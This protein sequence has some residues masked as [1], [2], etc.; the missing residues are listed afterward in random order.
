MLWCII[1]KR[2]LASANYLCQQSTL[3]KSFI[4]YQKLNVITPMNTNIES[5]HLRLVAHIKLVIVEKIAETNHSQQLKKWFKPI[6]CA[7]IAFF[8]ATNPYKKSNETQQ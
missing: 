2:T 7:I 8:G 1:H 3:Q 4:K 5:T 6:G